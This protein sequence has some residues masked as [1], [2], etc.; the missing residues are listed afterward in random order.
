MKHLALVLVLAS[1]LLF[2]CTPTKREDPDWMPVIERSL[3]PYNI[4]CPTVMQSEP[5]CLTSFHGNPLY[6]S[7]WSFEAC[8]QN[9]INY[10]AHLDAYQKCTINKLID[11]FSELNKNSVDTYNCMNS[12]AGLKPYR[13]CKPVDTEVHKF[14]AQY[15]YTGIEVYFGVPSCVRTENIRQLLE[16]PNTSVLASL[17]LID[18]KTDV[19]YFIG[20]SEKHSWRHDAKNSSEQILHFVRSI[21]AKIKQKK[22]ETADKFNC[23]ADRRSLC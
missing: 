7:P 2:G 21:Q 14:P 23:L 4:S 3:I 19:E 6:E 8:R 13:D 1:Q 10:H 22:S 16:D 11:I 5:Y 12:A 17:A 9:L 15:S 20:K 18:C